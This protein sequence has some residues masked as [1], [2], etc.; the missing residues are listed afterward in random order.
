MNGGDYMANK[1]EV[2][3]QKIKTKNHHLCCNQSKLYPSERKSPNSQ[4]KKNDE[5]RLSLAIGLAQGKSSFF[6]IFM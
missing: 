1:I 5:V 6:I 3:Y 4:K 2:Q